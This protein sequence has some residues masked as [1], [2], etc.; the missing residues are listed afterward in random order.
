MDSIVKQSL[1]MGASDT[2]RAARLRQ[3]Q[4]E[5]LGTLRRDFLTTH[6]TSDGLSAS[7]NPEH[8]RRV[9]QRGTQESAVTDRHRAS[10]AGWNSAWQN[11]QND[12]A[13]EEGLEDLNAGQTHRAR[14]LTA[15]PETPS[16]SYHQGRGALHPR[17]T[18]RGGRGGG[19]VGSNP[20][21]TARRSG[22]AGHP[23]PRIKP[24]SDAPAIS[25]VSHK[26][27]PTTLFDSAGSRVGESNV[28]QT[29]ADDLL[30]IEI[31]EP[32]NL[33]EPMQLSAAAHR[34]QPESA[35]P[36]G[37]LPFL[38]LLSS[39]WAKFLPML[40]NVLPA[41]AVEKLDSV[42]VDLQEQ[43][44]KSKGVVLRQSEPAVQQPKLSVPEAALKADK[45]AN[46]P[47]RGLASAVQQR[48]LAW[49]KDVIAGTGSSNNSV[50]GENISR[51]RFNRRLR[52]SVDSL[53]SVASASSSTALTER[54]DQLQLG[55]PRPT[56]ASAGTREK[57][58][59]TNPFGVASSSSASIRAQGYQL[60]QFL[61]SEARAQ[62]PAAA[63]RAEYTANSS[64]QLEKPTTK[65]II[66]SVL[67]GSIARPATAETCISSGDNSLQELSYSTSSVTENVPYR[68][69]FDSTG[70]ERT[71][72]QNS[73]S[74]MGVLRI[75]PA[76]SEDSTRPR[77]GRVIS[78]SETR[79]P[80]LN[81]HIVR[82]QDDH[83]NIRSAAPPSR[84]GRQ[85]SIRESS[86]PSRS[87][88]EPLDVL[89]RFHPR[90]GN[91]IVPPT[92]DM[93]PLQAHSH[94]SNR[95]PAVRAP[96]RPPAPALPSFLA[97]IQPSEDPGSAAAEQYA[98]R[99]INYQQG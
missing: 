80:Q 96:R 35:Q 93:T 17:G 10:L 55:E 4:M 34:N 86:N 33:P 65:P 3:I 45:E 49:S 37:Q 54:I 72:R 13:L 74:S 8:H 87:G 47:I 81:D 50:L 99:S 79:N 25:R 19:A 24:Q 95:A 89:P 64:R 29:Y 94:A 67:A 76:L 92:A 14:L 75:S 68:A 52:N 41:E 21:R 48:T 6:D 30:D 83:R 51:G 44:V 32:I 77:L 66:Q 82:T 42:S 58:S 26:P 53:A 46:I 98:G 63:L 38:D 1:T 2:E 27:A 91:Q 57:Y 90:L 59:T 62:D 60:P 85:G 71:L 12:E 18:G 36:S 5:A 28:S 9:N 16:G 20:R 73:S 43:V 56:V 97:N 31:T 88:P 39:E 15:V 61:R 84:P 7:L 23:I 40:K 11:L 70:G 69:D 22:K 78:R